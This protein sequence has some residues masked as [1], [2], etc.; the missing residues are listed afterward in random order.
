MYQQT[1]IVDDYTTEQMA[2]ALSHLGVDEVEYRPCTTDGCQYYATE[3][4]NWKCSRCYADDL[5]S[6][7]SASLAAGHVTKMTPHAEAQLMMGQ[8]HEPQRHGMMV[9]IFSV[10]LLL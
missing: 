8:D 9:T 5:S 1:S 3:E 10:L 2:T 6:S 4:R 7:Q